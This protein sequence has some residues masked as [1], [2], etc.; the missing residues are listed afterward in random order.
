LAPDERFPGAAELRREVA[1]LL[2]S[3]EDRMPR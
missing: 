3:A 2:G 1:S